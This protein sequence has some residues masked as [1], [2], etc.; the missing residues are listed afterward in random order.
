MK[1]QPS[2]SLEKRAYRESGHAVMSFLISKG[3]TDK[4][5]PVGRDGILPEFK[6]V[7]IEA[8][9]TDWAETTTNLGSLMTVPQVLIAGHMAESI[10]YNSVEEIPPRKSKL[11]KEARNLIDG[12]ID[13]YATDD[14]IKK[15]SLTTKFLKDVYA[16]VEENLRTH[17]ISVEALANA[18]LQKRTLSEEEAFE[19]IER[20]IPEDLKGKAKT[21]L[22]R[23][24]EQ[25]LAEILKGIKNQESNT[26]QIA[27]KS[28]WWAFWKK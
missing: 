24:I 17:W 20:N 19:I 4:Y 12:Y 1:S 6:Q 21:A 26:K 3:F 16:Y 23:T 25:K 9:S 18:L 5:I 27:N 7:T 28:P 11:I 13:E 22:S 2:N 10:K 15:H 14:F 8:E